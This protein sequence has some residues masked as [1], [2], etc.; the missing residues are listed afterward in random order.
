[1]AAQLKKRK[2]N[3]NSKMYGFKTFA[4]PGCPVFLSGGTFKENVQT[5]L[6]ECGTIEEF[7]VHG[8]PTWSTSLVH[9]NNSHNVLVPLY[10]IE[11]SVDQHSSNPF[12]DHCRCIGW[13]HHLVSKRRYHFIIPADDEWNK[14][15][16]E[17]VLDDNEENQATHLLHGLIHCNGYGHL[18]SINGL[19]GGSKILFGREIMDLWDRICTALRAWKITVEDTSMKRSMNLRLL[20]GVAYG[21]SWFGRWGYKFCHGSFGVNVQNYGAAIG[22]LSS[23]NIDEVINDFVQAR[24]SDRH[25]KQIVEVYRQASDTHLITL[26]DLIRFMLSLKTNAPAQIKTIMPAAVSPPKPPITKPKKRKSPAME[27]EPKYKKFSTFATEMASRWP[28]R[29]LEYAAEVIVDALKEKGGGMSRQEVRDAG[30]LHIGDTGLLDFVIKSINNYVVGDYVVLRAA[31]QST[32]IL[33]FTVRQVSGNTA[34][35]HDRE[36]FTEPAVDISPAAVVGDPPGLD[37]YRDIKYLY[38][39]V[40]E[41]Y[42]MSGLPELATRVILDSKHYVKEW[43]FKDEDD[44]LLRFI[45]RILETSEELETRF[46]RMSEPGELVALP[47]YATIGELKSAIEDVY[48]DTYCMMERF[49]VGEVEGLN[50]M[51]DDEVVF[52]N[53]E[54]GAHV[55]VRGSGIDLENE[56][57]H[58]GGADNWTVDCS[59]GAKDDDGERMVACDICEVWQHTRCIGIGEKETVPQLFICSRCS[60]S[61]MAPSTEYAM[62]MQYM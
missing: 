9:H 13:S 7:T 11:E 30:R 1:M 37:I 39:H 50:F 36:A 25:M 3:P 45:C 24:K 32:K 29:R 54:S 53:M 60:A 33:Q 58:E 57:K 44:E 31:N 43:P 21:H 5:L 17:S 34:T 8:M 46:T 14:T 18:L 41:H 22:V 23:L 19:E 35:V 15:L 59:C 40:L 28:A 42:P 38:K 10:T 52:G 6:R 48:R 56:L 61:L 20:H 55:L 26:R 12:C 27:E 49:V 2:R 51:D 62:D 16:D 47:P 4:D